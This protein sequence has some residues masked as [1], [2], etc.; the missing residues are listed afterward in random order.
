ML[1]SN[2]RYFSPISAT[3]DTITP[4]IKDGDTMRLLFVEDERPLA[5]AVAETLGKHHYIVDLAHNGEDGL[6]FALSGVYDV[7][8]L[9]IMLPRRTGLEVLRELRQVGIK[10]PVILLTALGQTED[11]IEGLDAG[12]DDYLAKPFQMGELLARLRALLRRPHEMLQD[13]VRAYGD[14]TVNPHTLELRGRNKTFSLT[15]KEC[16]LLDYL[17]QNR[18]IVLS[19]DAIIEKVWGW[20]SDVVDNNVQAYISFL[21]KKLKFLESTVTIR[22]VRGAGYVLEGE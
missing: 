8:V 10:T 18:G 12:A 4:K 22:N 3:G 2:I 6:N 20:D 19:T 17:M 11:K 13:G 21:R 1:Q 7:I 9:D 15:K 5:E 14:I 16:Q